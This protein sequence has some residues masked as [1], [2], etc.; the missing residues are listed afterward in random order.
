LIVALKSI[1]WGHRSFGEMIDD[2]LVYVDKTKYIHDLLQCQ[3]GN[4]FFLSR[5]RLFGRST[6]LGVIEELLTG[7]RNRFDGLWIGRSDYRFEPHPVIR[8]QLSGCGHSAASL[9]ASLVHDVESIAKKNHLALKGGSPGARLAGLVKALQ[10]ERRSKVAVLVD[11][12]DYPVYDNMGDPKT[13][14]ANAMVLHDFYG[15]LRRPDVAERVH[16][17]LVIGITNF[18]LPLMELGPD[19]LI[20]ISL[21]PRFSGICGYTLDELDLNFGGNMEALLPKLKEKG[22]IE[23]EATVADL[24]SQIERWYGGYSFGGQARLINPWS[25]MELFHEEY[26]G[27][28]WMPR[29][30]SMSLMSLT[31]ARPAD[32]LDDALA[33]YAGAR[34][35]RSELSLYQALPLLFSSGY[36]TI[37]E[38]IEPG[39]GGE[40][41]SAAETLYSFKLPNREVESL[42]NS[43]FF[44]IPKNPL[45]GKLPR[46]MD[47][48]LQRALLERDAITL[49]EIITDFMSCF[50]I[51]EREVPEVAVMVPLQA[52]IAI[53]GMR[54]LRYRPDAEGRPTLAFELSGEV[55]AHVKM[56]Y[57]QVQDRLEKQ[58]DKVLASF[59]R[60]IFP[61]ETLARILG[62][63]AESKLGSKNIKE[64]CKEFKIKEFN[65]D[66]S[67]RLFSVI[68][69]RYLSRHEIDQA[70]AS[71]VK[72]TRSPDEIERILG[73]LASKPELTERRINAIL[74]RDARKAAKQHVD[75]G[76]NGFHPYWIKELIVVG[77]AVC[78][79]DSHLR[80]KA[81][82][83]SK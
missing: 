30:R 77:L 59:G 79:H 28:L 40:G 56:A 16:F 61:A 75:A 71:Q 1:G 27:A 9:K 8:L 44:G 83:G 76:R 60:A 21:D 50:K 39:G 42:Y 81:V 32:F 11:E 65:D 14:K 26:L 31:K 72:R 43:D 55:E 82:F 24:R 73:R 41:G 4:S 70:I 10:R 20:D 5:P 54:L 67:N 17:T 35:R 47:K 58:E 62:E 63:V 69:D 36:L 51:E 49:A 74:A 53:R 23:P 48:N 18:G 22:E 12:Y 52:L 34:L 78:V 33:S 2:N 66:D 57:C 13:A 37:D 64:I 80:F 7:N 3:G 45:T 6:L 46:P 29:S 25:I 19:H 68:A 15:A 38:I